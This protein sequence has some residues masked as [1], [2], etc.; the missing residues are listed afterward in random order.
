MSAT[1]PPRRGSVRVTNMRVSMTPD[2]QPEEDESVVVVDR[3]NPILGNRHILY[4]K[5]DLRE[6]ERVIQ[7]YQKDLD[8]DLAGDGPMSHELKA[9]ADRVGAGERI[10]LVCWCKPSPCHADILAKRIYLMAF[11]TVI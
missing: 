10:C 9:L 3:T 8:V 6:R 4:R 11:P 5:S 2:A 7:A 1:K